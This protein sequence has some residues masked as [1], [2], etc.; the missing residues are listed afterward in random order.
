MLV[1]LGAQSQRRIPL[2]LISSL[3]ASL[4]Y[5]LLAMRFASESIDEEIRIWLLLYGY[6]VFLQW[7][8]IK[9]APQHLCDSFKRSIEKLKLTDAPSELIVAMAMTGAVSIF[10][11]HR[12]RWL[13]EDLRRYAVMCGTTTWKEMQAV[14]KSYLW[15]DLLDGHAGQRIFNSFGMDKTKIVP[16]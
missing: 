6:H 11:L 14:L 5:R 3:I 8:D 12:E 13:E 7:Q 4:L 10:Y 1:N 15:I 16:L 9:L 2:S